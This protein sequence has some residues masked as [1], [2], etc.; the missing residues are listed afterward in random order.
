MSTLTK[1][2]VV[3]LVVFAIAFTMSTVSFVAQ[4]TNWR[5]LAQGYQLE[6]QAT[7][8]HLRNVL[9]SDAAEIASNRDALNAHI[10]RIKQLDTE[11]QESN[12]AASILRADLA[13]ARAESSS[14]QS[15]AR[16]LAGEFKVG[17]AGWAEIRKQR[18][19]L[20]NRNVDLEKRNLDLSERVNEQTS[21]IL[22]M[23]KYLRQIE[24]Q[25]KILQ[26]EN[27]R[28]GQVRQRLSDGDLSALADARQGQIKPLTPVS[29]S[30]I[31]GSIDEVSGN[32][33]TVTVGSADGV[34]KGMVFVI[35]RDLD[36]VADLEIVR[37]E[38]NKAAGK[39]LRSRGTP[40]VGDRI[41]DEARFGMAP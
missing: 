8:A 31:R 16:L 40:R 3:L 12:K 37:V 9:A 27:G 32:L 20:E 28:L 22:V 5:E 35:Y 4:S 11:V 18:D 34:S 17:Q 19:G 30:P 10:A 6:V 39:I 24:E 15:T 41:A 26:D 21:K 23:Q 7:D 33:A 36:Y 38:P 29:A 25:N 13:K 2:L 1:I 14:M